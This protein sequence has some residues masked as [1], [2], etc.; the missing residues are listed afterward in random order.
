[1]NPNLLKITLFKY[2]R[3]FLYKGTSVAEEHDVSIFSL[4]DWGS[5]STEMLVPYNNHKLFYLGHRG[6][7]PLF[8]FYSIFFK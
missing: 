6:L 5:S 1:M 7:S 3:M 2:V 8:R 4:E